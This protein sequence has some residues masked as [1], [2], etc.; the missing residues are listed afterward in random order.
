MIARTSPF[1]IRESPV[2]QCVVRN[3]Y[4][5]LLRF[6]CSLLSG[7]QVS[8]DRLVRGMA[9]IRLVLLGGKCPPASFIVVAVLIG[10]SASGSYTDTVKL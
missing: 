3:I 10:C 4:G 8:L 9:K 6:L 5:D 2:N 1:T 7:S